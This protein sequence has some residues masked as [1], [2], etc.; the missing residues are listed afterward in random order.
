MSH[1]LSRLALLAI[2]CTTLLVACGDKKAETTTAAEAES[3]SGTI[4]C[5]GPAM[6]GDAGLPANFPILPEM[7]L[8]TAEDKGPTHVV[9]GYAEDGIDGVYNELK[10]RLQEEQYTILFNEIEK[11]RGD[12]EISYKT[13]DKKTSGQIALRASCDN[14][15][16]SVHITAR[17]A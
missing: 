8:V 6:S 5:E 2:A 17:P 14:G 11:E 9:D 3:G 4:T 12:A 10:D 13:P 16:T 15:N 1:R 7:T